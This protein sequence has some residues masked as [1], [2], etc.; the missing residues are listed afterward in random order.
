[1]APPEAWQPLPPNAEIVGVEASWRL[2][3]LPADFAATGVGMT[4]FF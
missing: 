4:C 3:S 2:P 1:M